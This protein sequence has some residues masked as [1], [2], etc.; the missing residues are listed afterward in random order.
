MST[1]TR[2]AVWSL[3]TDSGTT[4]ASSFSNPFKHVAAACSFATRSVETERAQLDLN[5]T[6]ALVVEQLER[7]EILVGHGHAQPKAEHLVH[8]RARLAAHTSAA[9]DLDRRGAAG[10]PDTGAN[11]AE[12]DLGSFDALCQRQSRL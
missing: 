12:I 6:L 5:R 9:A 7:V 2:Q 11:G 3:A 10:N 4:R 8:R 1:S